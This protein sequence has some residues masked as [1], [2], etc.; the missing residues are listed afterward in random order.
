MVKHLKLGQ[1]YEDFE[2]KK[3]LVTILVNLSVDSSVIPVS[4][5]K[6]V[7]HFLTPNIFTFFFKFIVLNRHSPL[8]RNKVE[9]I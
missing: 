1:N 2:I 9:L 7:Q 6:K 4:K 5:H 3:L 8:C